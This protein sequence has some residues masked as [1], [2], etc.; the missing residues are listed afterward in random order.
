MKSYLVQI[1][2]WDP[3]L[4]NFPTDLIPAHLLRD[5]FRTNFPPQRNIPCYS[6]NKEWMTNLGSSSD[7]LQEIEI[8]TPRPLLKTVQTAKEGEK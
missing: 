6:D 3:L 7:S 4:I 2:S 5:P 8:I 1:I